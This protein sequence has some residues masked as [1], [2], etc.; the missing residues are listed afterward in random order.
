MS[1]LYGLYVFCVYVCV[2]VAKGQN[3]CTCVVWLSEL[4]VAAGY[5]S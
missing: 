5:C 1:C 3:D 4:G 2:D